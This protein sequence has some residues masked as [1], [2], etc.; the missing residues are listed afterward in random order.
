[1]E[2]NNSLEPAVAIVALEDSFVPFYRDL[3][4]LH[5]VSSWGALLQNGSLSIEMF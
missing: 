2:R 5:K 1:V 3:V 4:K